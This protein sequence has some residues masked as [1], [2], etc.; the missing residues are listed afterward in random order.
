[1]VVTSSRDGDA[2]TLTTENVRS[3]V[4]DGDALSGLGVA[5]V[6]VD[7]ESVSVMPGALPV[8][9]QAGKRAGLSGPMNEVYKRPFCYVYPDAS[10]AYAAFAAYHLSEWAIIGNGQACALPRSLLTPEIAA[11]HNLIH[12]G[13]RPGDLDAAPEG[14][15]WEGWNVSVGARAFERAS[16]AFVFPASD[17]EHL[18]AV[19]TAPTRG[20]RSL[21]GI[22][23]FSSRSGLPDYLVF[24]GGRALAAGFF[25]PE[26]RLPAR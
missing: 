6:D 9:P 1:M 20:E 26:W 2:V 24:G 23:P 19:L 25:D 10:T 12:L 13:P 11:S 8:G 22:S 7:G 16:M 21:Y 18:Q 4:L 3:L 14:V 17:D 5:T 15:T